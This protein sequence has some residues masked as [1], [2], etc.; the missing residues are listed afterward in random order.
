MQTLREIP[1]HKLQY[2][3]KNLSK[4]MICK[5]SDGCFAELQKESFVSTGKWKCYIYSPSYEYMGENIISAS[6]LYPT[7]NP[8]T[9]NT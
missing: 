1:Q 9:D 2:N 8:S 4:G 5:L 6:D 3:K 7:E